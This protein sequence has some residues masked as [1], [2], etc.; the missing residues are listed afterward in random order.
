VDARAD[1]LVEF[2]QALEG[3]PHLGGSPVPA[4][5][6]LDDEFVAQQLLSMAGPDASRL[7]RRIAARTSSSALGEKML[8]VASYLREQECEVS[9][10]LC[11]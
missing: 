11:H 3:M 8:A 9:G 4:L 7:A 1:A 2:A 6:R 5:E 10:K